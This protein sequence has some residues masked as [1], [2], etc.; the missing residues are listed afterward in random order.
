MDGAY[1]HHGFGSMDGAYLYCEAQE[2][3]QPDHSEELMVVLYRIFIEN[4]Y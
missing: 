3:I 1:L 2:G 4:I